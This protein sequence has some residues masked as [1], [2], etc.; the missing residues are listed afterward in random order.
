LR[1]EIATRK[2]KQS[3][4]FVVGFPVIS[5]LCRPKWLFHQI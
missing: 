1:Y 4:Q 5:I 3:K 2:L